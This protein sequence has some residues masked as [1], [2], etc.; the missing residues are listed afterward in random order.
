MTYSVLS[1]MLS[2][3]ITF[4]TVSLY[5][6]SYCVVVVGRTQALKSVTS[7]FLFWQ[8]SLHFTFS[9]FTISLLLLDVTDNNKLSLRYTFW[10]IYS[11]SQLHAFSDLAVRASVLYR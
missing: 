7:V 2:L 5:M 6:R 1:E 4:T 10:Y 9:P 8:L 11:Q 3:Y